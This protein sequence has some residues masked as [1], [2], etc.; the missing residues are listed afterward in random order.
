MTDEA[1]SVANLLLDCLCKKLAVRENPPELCCLRFGTDVTQDVLP[2]DICCE[3][4][5]YVRFGGM[6]AS[7]NSFPEPD[8]ADNCQGAMWALE[9]E[10]GVLRC[11]DPTECEAW[12]AGAAQH[13]SDRMA[14]VE[15][16]CCFKDAL[17]REN[18][19]LNMFVGQGDALPIEGNCNGATQIVTVQIHGACCV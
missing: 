8:P 9:L 17:E 4:L 6:F 16:L 12:N 19:Y 5:G 2:E 14:M 7:S 11:G 10:M 3:G 13:I 18:L 1:L 15:A